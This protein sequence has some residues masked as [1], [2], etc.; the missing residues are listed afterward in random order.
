MATEYPVKLEIELEPV[1]QPWITVGAGDCVVQ[2]QL[3]AISKFD[4]EFVANTKSKITVTHFDKLPSD[5]STAVIIKQLS[6][7]GISDPR[8]VWAG[9]YQP[10]Y[11]EP[12][13]SSQSPQPSKVLTAHPYLGWNGTWSLEFEIPVF[14]WM[15]QVQNLG[16]I[17]D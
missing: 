17:Y 6:F 15:H 3:T 12:W 4:F 7:F 1:G 13:L 16:W 9:Q 11:P 5:S 10:E 14:T 8:F 2:Q